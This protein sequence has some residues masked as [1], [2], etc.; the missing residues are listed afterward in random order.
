MNQKIH[1]TQ[2]VL[3]V[4]SIM[5]GISST[6]TICR[7]LDICP[8]FKSLPKY[9]EDDY[10]NL[11]DSNGGILNHWCYIAEIIRPYDLVYNTYQPSCI[12]QD[13]DGF[14]HTV[15]LD[16]DETIKMNRYEN[17]EYF[18]QRHTLAILYAKRSQLDQTCEGICSRKE[19]VKI[20]PCTYAEILEESKKTGQSCCYSC[21]GKATTSPLSK[22]GKCGFALYCS[23]ACQ[24]S[25]WSCHK[26][27]CK[28]I[29]ILD[30][31]VKLVHTPLNDDETTF[32]ILLTF[33]DDT[34]VTSTV[35]ARKKR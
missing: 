34:K 23:K 35:E 15:L 21:G 6:S 5:D 33:G 11:I 32:P 1:R 16:F 14:A 18:P 13:K 9:A 28:D 7:G 26:K 3:L 19:R 4:Y 12:V 17:M 10:S 2:G 24:V 8:V 29:K 22:C 31:L 27:L 30:C 25:H 20:F